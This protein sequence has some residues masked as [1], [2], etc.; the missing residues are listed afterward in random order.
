MSKLLTDS[1]VLHF[2]LFD[3]A[4]PDDTPLYCLIA[5]LKEATLTCAEMRVT[6][7][8]EQPEVLRERISAVEFT[9]TDAWRQ[10]LALQNEF[11]DLI[12]KSFS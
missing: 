6:V 10:L 5:K 7:D 4:A 3:G 12:E 9:L 1:E 11:S 8:F 2:L